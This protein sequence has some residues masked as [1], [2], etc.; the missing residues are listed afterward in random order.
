MNITEAQ[1]KQL[2]EE[3]AETGAKRA[4]ERLGLHDEDA[5]K[6]VHEM[7]SLLEAWRDVRRTAWHTFVQSIVKGLLLVIVIGTTA[8]LWRNAP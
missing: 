4:L 8:Y 6:D 1:L 2:L 5:A 3:A 7:R